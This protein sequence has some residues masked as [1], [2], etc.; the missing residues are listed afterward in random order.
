MYQKER[1][2]TL[3]N[4]IQKNGY[5]TT[6]NLVKEFHYSVA[7]VN[8]DLNVL[9]KQGFVIRSYGGV[10]IVQ[11]KYA[12]YKFRQHKMREEKRRISK[13]ACELVKD[14]ETIFID[15][16]TTTDY[17]ADY[18]TNKKN[19]T[20]ITNNT[21]LCMQLSIAGIKVICLGGK[22]CEAP[23]FLG[24]DIT[25]ENALKY[26][27]DKTFFST[28]MFTEDGRIGCGGTWRSFYIATHSNSK[29]T[30]YLAASDKITKKSD[31][32][33]FLFDFDKLTGVI[34][35]HEFS[36]DV[37]KKYPDTEFYKV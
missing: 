14:G 18:L 30:Y 12:P 6:K 16:S 36:D 22:V 27:A 31:I 9:Q 11:K 2:D 33:L 32:K 26:G 8:R 34:S 4:F 25:I 23:Y 17:M 15:A 1:L 20:V 24:G 28:S 19:I 10:E 29:E 21:Y 13:K 7:S 3:L 5:V 37:K 35:D